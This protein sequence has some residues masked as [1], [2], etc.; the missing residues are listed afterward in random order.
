MGEIYHEIEH[1][2]FNEE[3]IIPWIIQY[4]EKLISDGIDLHVYV[5]DNNSTDKSVEM[6]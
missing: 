5:F 2:V 6:L 3:F 1:K 4:W